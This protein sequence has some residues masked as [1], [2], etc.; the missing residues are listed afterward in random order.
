M[1][2]Y[3]FIV[4]ALTA[5]SSAF[6]D[7]FEQPPSVTVSHADLDL[8]SSTGRAIT[9]ALFACALAIGARCA[10]LAASTC[11][12]GST[13]TGAG[14]GCG[15]SV[16]NKAACKAACSSAISGAAASGAGTA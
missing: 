14:A 13:N 6:A 15:L 11:R 5:T 4:L 8:S 9:A 2:K 12:L 3:C 1:L 7:P 10:A 16:A